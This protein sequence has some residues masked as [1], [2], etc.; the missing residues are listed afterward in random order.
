MS[1]GTGYENPLDMISD[2]PRISGE[3]V[4]KQLSDIITSMEVAIEKG[5]NLQIGIV[6][7]QCLS[8]MKAVR[9]QIYFI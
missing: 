6:F 9:D 8:Q 1:A 7:G 4:A 3:Y 5:D 2:S